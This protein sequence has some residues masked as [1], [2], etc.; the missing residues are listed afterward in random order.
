M[1]QG[2]KNSSR[3]ISRQA[4]ASKL[5][6][7]SPP[8]L[9]VCFQQSKKQQTKKNSDNYFGIGNFFLHFPSF[10]NKSRNQINISRFSFFLFQTVF[11]L[12][13][14]SSSSVSRRSWNECDVN[15]KVAQ[16]QTSSRQAKTKFWI[17]KK[18]SVTRQARDEKIDRKLKC[19]D[20]QIEV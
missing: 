11:L 9:C 15:L 1:L 12:K 13:S 5:F 19:K 18:S 6:H 10:F 7:F 17:Q 3:T 20:E 8:A 4:T 16:K 14:I 2:L